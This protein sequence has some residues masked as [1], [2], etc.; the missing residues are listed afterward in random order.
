MQRLEILP[1]THMWVKHKFFLACYAIEPMAWIRAEPK[2]FEGVP[3]PEE[4]AA[5]VKACL[6]ENFAVAGGEVQ[7]FNPGYYPF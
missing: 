2:N 7:T 1:M 3:T 4:M 6:A 5:K